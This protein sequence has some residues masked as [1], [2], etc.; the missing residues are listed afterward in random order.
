MRKFFTIIF[1][2]SVIIVIGLFVFMLTLDVNQYKPLLIEKI[3]QAIQKDVRIGNISLNLLPRM[4]IA[5][6]GISIKEVNKTWDDIL[7]EV[8][9]VDARVRL[10]PLIRRDIQIEHLFIRDMDVFF[11]NNIKLGVTEAV[12]TNVSLYGP[13]EL[14]ARLSFFGRGKENIK[15]E[16]LLYPELESK[17]PYVKNLDL[18]IDLARFNVRNALDAL[19]QGDLA[20]QLTGKDI[21]GEL[22]ISAKTIHLDPKKIYDVEAYVVLTN[23]AIDLPHIKGGLRDIEAEARIGKG[24]LVIQSLA[25]LFGRGNFLAKG[26][27]RDIQND[28]SS[29]FDIML[30]DIN[31][32]DLLPTPIPG[33]PHFEGVLDIDITCSAMGLEVPA[34][35]DTLSASGALKLDRAVLRNMNILTVALNKLN[36]LPGVVQKLRRKLPERYRELLGEMDTFFKPIEIDFNIENTRLYFQKT[37]VES[38]AFYLVGMGYIGTNGEISVNANLFIPQDLSEAFIG[39]AREFEFLQNSKGM[40]TMPIDIYGRFPDISVRPDL[41]YVIQKLAVSKGQELL[42]SIFKKRQPV[43]PEVE[44]GR[45]PQP[46]DRGPETQQEEPEE[47]EPAEAIIRTIFDIISAP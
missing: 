36:M 38:D 14:D 21:A 26:V 24:S 9:S 44:P 15:L 23:G 45:E 20:Q 11:E 31:L 10:L 4:T 34:I 13:I 41:D 43:T 40:I 25:G 7:L 30:K 3:E 46:E 32:T 29:D 6:N 39:V 8:G 5:L 33:K 17:K 37:V 16:A 12:L 28:R 47:V 2:L 1:L 35:L 22:S 27:V 19:G 42:E 18:K